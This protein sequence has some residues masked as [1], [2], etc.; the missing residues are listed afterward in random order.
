LSLLIVLGLPR[1]SIIHSSV[2]MIGLDDVD[3]SIYIASASLEQSSITVKVLN[4]LMP[5]K[6]SFE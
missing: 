1:C 6:L 2:R 4:F 5:I 3:V